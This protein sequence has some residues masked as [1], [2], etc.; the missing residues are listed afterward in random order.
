MRS[1]RLSRTWARAAAGIL[2]GL[3]V[4][5]LAGCGTSSDGTDSGAGAVTIPHAFGQTSVPQVP[6]RIVAIGNQ[7]LDAALALGVTPVG[8]LDNVAMVSKSRTAWDPDTLGRA[9]QLSNNDL[10]ESVAALDPDLILADGYY[11]DEKMYT[12]FSK[13]APTLP[14]LSKSMVTPWQDQTTALGKVLHKDADAAA[15]V[16]KVTGRIDALAQQYPG[17]HGKTF[18]STWLA[19]PSQL[20]VLIDPKDGSTSLFTALGLHIPEQLA[21]LPSNGGRTQLSPERVDELQVDLL[22]AA[23]SPGLADTYR[24][25]PGY[26]NLPAV[27]KHAVAELD[28]QD[29]AGLNQPTA[30]SLPYLLDKIE[31][32]LA[33]AAS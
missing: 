19:G 16:A 17:L 23:T 18:A 21:A 28:T 2:A 7:W 30:L 5:G 27:R 29:I 26:D 31:P 1:A 22:L 9:T 24:H 25:F 12:T 20:M 33:A 6:K 3:V 4:V 10:A 32:A 13:I 14:A 8:Y 15:I 11:A